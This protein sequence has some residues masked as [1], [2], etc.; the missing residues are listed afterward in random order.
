MLCAYCHWLSYPEQKRRAV[1]LVVHPEWRRRGLGSRMLQEVLAEARA[2]GFGRLDVWAYNAGRPAAILAER[3]AFVAGRTVLQM[4]AASLA[5]PDPALPADVRLRPF[6]I[7]RDVAS[8]LAFNREAFAEH[9]ENGAWTEAD[10]RNRLAETWFDAG[11]FQLAEQDGQLVGCIWVKVAAD[12]Q[13]RRIG[14][15]YILG[16]SP[17]YEGRGLGRSLALAGL[18]RMRERG[19]VDGYVYLDADNTPALK[20]YLS[21][22]FVDYQRHICYTRS[23]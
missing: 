3:F 21:A 19:C 4:R 8:W 17:R 16:V 14:E 7:D 9:P 11:D 5:A 18:R 12:S 15:I 23:L 22:G 10:L 13:G 6:D 2:A 20:V 1:E